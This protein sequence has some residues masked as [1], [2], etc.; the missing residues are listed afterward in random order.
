MGAAEECG[1]HTN[2]HINSTDEELS[3]LEAINRGS[4]KR[5]TNKAYVFFVEDQ[6]SVMQICTT[7]GP[8]TNQS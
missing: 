2:R 1:E 5:N 6:V 7:L 3:S 4:E 8:I